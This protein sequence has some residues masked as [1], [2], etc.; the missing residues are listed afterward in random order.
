M[1]LHEL[2]MICITDIIYRRT[3]S[4]ADMVRG[5]TL[6]YGPDYNWDTVKISLMNR[7]VFPFRGHITSLPEIT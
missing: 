4:D 2:G 1:T 6:D 3:D 5:I 7:P